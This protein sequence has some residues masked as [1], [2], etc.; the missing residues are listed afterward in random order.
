MQVNKYPLYVFNVRDYNVKEVLGQGSYGVVALGFHK[1]TKLPVA[2]KKIE[3]FQR[4]LFC[5]RTLREIKFL[6]ELSHPNIIKILDIQ[7]PASFNTFKEVYVVQEYMDAD[8]NT[9]IQ[10]QQLSDDH[11]K[12]FL[13]Q[14]LKGVKYLHSCGVIH[15][16]LKPANLLVNENCDLKICDF[17]LAR[18]DVNPAKKED[19]LAFLTEYVATRW[20]RAPEIM[21]SSAEYSKAI[22]LWSIGCIVAEMLLREPFLP[23]TDYRNQLALIFE[24]LGTPTD[25]EI[26]GIKLK[27]AREYVQ[28]QKVKRKIPMKRIFRKAN[29]LAVDFIEKTV[30]FDPAKR[31][32]IDQALEHPYLQ[33][34]RNKKEEISGPRIPSDFFFFDN[35]KDQL[36]LLDLK[37]ML[38][39]EIIAG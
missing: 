18:M 2:I 5:L 26:K 21:L 8:L 35:Y 16:D 29:P 22:D 34:F 9:V 37:R 14:I 30:R 38:Y 6:K 33:D 27:K 4:T 25:E 7:K 20:Y 1:K 28:S 36:K 24:V 10:T 39:A 23:G 13:Y 32:T 12:Y 17:G 19:K 15:R 31:L 11:I 3:P